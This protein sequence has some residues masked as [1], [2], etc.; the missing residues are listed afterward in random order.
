VSEIGRR[1]RLERW[2]EGE[3][4]TRLEGCFGVLNGWVRMSVQAG[5][6]GQTGPAGP[7]GQ[8]FS[9]GYSI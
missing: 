8:A 3:G 5:Q 6:A 7:A 1:R 2:G 9:C 4:G